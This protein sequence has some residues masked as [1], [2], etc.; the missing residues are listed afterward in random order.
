LALQP[1]PVGV[2][3]LA[4][5]QEHAHVPVFEGVSYCEAVRRAGDGEVLR[6]MPDS[7]QVCGWAPVVL[8]LKEPQGRFEKGLQ[9]RLAYPVA[10]LLL[11][12]MEQFPG[13]PQVVLVR[14]TPDVLQRMI[15]AAGPGKMWAGHGGKV[16][17]SAVPRFTGVWAPS[18]HRLIEV[19]NRPLAALARSSRWQNLTR[20]LFR[21][22]MVTIGFDAV[23][24]RTLA[25]MSICRNSTVVPLLTGQ[26]NVSF[27][28][29]GG[30]T[31]GANDPAHLT[32]GWPAS[33]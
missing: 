15:D 14:S 33:G 11:A 9:P 3:V 27:F 25:D 4:S 31:W 10:G 13:A 1:P 12:P 28:C 30:I 5:R 18:K 22:R 17:M 24:S 21:S 26:A 8:G 6:V 2:R 20:W 29:S 7:I 32:S 23:I 19:V 16:D